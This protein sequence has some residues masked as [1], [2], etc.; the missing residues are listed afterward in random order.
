[1]FAD[2]SAVFPHLT[3]EDIRLLPN[4][5]WDAFTAVARI[6][7]YVKLTHGVQA[8]RAGK[9]AVG[10][11]LG[12]IEAERTG[13]QSDA[14]NASRFARFKADNAKHGLPVRDVSDAALVALGFENL[15]PDQ[16]TKAGE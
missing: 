1:M 12:T 13:I 7:R 11:L 16:T 3:L 8:A 9:E 5:T 10:Q 6:R 15:T 4:E 2:I 14:T